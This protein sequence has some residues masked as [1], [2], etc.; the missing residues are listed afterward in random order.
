MKEVYLIQERIS[1]YYRH[2]KEKKV[3]KI[4]LL[5]GPHPKKLIYNLKTVEN[6]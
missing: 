4:Y 3:S 1:Y 5:S 6:T 2:N